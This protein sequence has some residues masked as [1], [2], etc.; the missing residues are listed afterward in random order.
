MSYNFIFDE[1][2]IPMG[3]FDRVENV[4]IEVNKRTIENLD[5][6][7]NFY[8]LWSGCGNYLDK[9]KV[10][11]INQG[12]MKLLLVSDGEALQ[13]MTLDWTVDLIKK[14]NLDKT[15]YEIIYNSDP[16]RLKKQ[17]SIYGFSIVLD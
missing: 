15:I 5:V 1:Y 2:N 17:F 14:F 6:D 8:P 3:F 4:G 9:S 10:E 12:K 7:S 13:K 16:N 11:L